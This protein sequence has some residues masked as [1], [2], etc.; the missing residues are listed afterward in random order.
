MWIY[1]GSAGQDITQGWCRQRL[2]AWPTPHRRQVVHDEELGTTTHLVVAGEKHQHTVVFV[3]GRHG[4][5]A[6]S[7]GLIDVLAERYRVIV[8]DLPGE[9]GLGSGGRPNTARLRDYGTWLDHVLA[10]AGEDPVTVMGHGFGA[11]VALAATPTPAVRE[12]I[13]L[14]PGG[15]IWPAYNP[16]ATAA[17]LAWRLWPS[18]RSSARLVRSLSGPRSSCPELED[19]LRIV[20]R[21]VA[22]S[23]TPPAN[24]W[25]ARRWRDTPCTVAVGAHDR[26]F[27]PAR[28]IPAAGCTVDATGVIVAGAGYLLPYERPEAVVSLLGRRR[29]ADR[30][31]RRPPGTAPHGSALAACRRP[32]RAAVPASAAP[33]EGRH[34]V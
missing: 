7:I 31:L 5:A 34:D 30:L 23:S 20:G 12:L 10:E 14:N 21:R 2:D 19:W 29:H 24:R 8:V 26:V 25:L 4:N 13:L 28:L 33:E 18:A 6:T 15:L 17:M 9:A 1:R 22:C 3:P 32:R 11:A 27:T 16:A